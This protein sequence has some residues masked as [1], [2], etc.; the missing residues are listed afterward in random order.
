MSGSFDTR[1]LSRYAAGVVLAAAHRAANSSKMNFFSPW[2]RISQPIPCYSYYY[3]QNKRV[4]HAPLKRGW[5]S[6]R[7]SNRSGWFESRG[8]DGH[9]LCTS[10]LSSPNV[11]KVIHVF[12]PRICP[13][14]FTARRFPV[15]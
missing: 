1:A 14:E 11:G 9:D 13:L 2:T 8:I 6:R 3:T 15:W 10:Y 4:N 5:L 12:A 7:S